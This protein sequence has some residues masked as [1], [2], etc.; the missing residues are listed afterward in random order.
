MDQLPDW[1]PID[2]HKEILASGF[3]YKNMFYYYHDPKTAI[4]CGMSAEQ[5]VAIYIAAKYVAQVAVSAIVVSFMEDI[6]AQRFKVM[7]GTQSVDAY[8]Q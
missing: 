2:F 1:I 7:A 6:G 8:M 5:A 3:Q 4:K